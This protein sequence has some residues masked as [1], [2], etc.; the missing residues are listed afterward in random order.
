MQC[1][2]CK[3]MKSGIKT[4]LVFV[5][6]SIAT[7]IINDVYPLA[8]E[9]IL[10]K[11][12]PSLSSL[13]P[14]W[15]VE[16]VAFCS[17]GFGMFLILKEK[18]VSTKLKNIKQKSILETNILGYPKTNYLTES[19]FKQFL[20][21]LVRLEAFINPTEKPPMSAQRFVNLFTLMREC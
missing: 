10:N 8:K 18:Y 12:I 14:L 11:T 4:G 16:I 21:G 15:I 17:M 2:K 19:D 13:N 20:W 5:G 1:N 3:D 7:L 6:G 9:Y